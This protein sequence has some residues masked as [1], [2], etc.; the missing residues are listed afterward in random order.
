MIEVFKVLTINEHT[1]AFI[2]NVYLNVNYNGGHCGTTNIEK[3]CD[4]DTTLTMVVTVSMVYGTR[5][6]F[7]SVGRL[8]APGIKM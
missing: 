5:F 6:S 4:D 1:V 8:K 3:S 7:P 2:S